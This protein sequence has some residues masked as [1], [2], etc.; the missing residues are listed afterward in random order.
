MESKKS[1]PP[2]KGMRPTQTPIRSYPKCAFLKPRASQ[3][4][5]PPRM[6]ILP[7]LRLATGE[8]S[9]VTSPFLI[10][11]ADHRGEGLESKLKALDFGE[12]E[13]L[14]TRDLR[15]TL[16]AIEKHMPVAILVDTLSRAGTE[17]LRAIDFA[18][19][20]DP[21]IPLL[22]FSEAR[23]VGQLSH[24]LNV[25]AHEA[26]DLTDRHA[27]GDEIFLRLSR[28]MT[29]TKR[30]EEIIDLRHRA[31][32]DDR[33][34]LLRVK[35]F[36]ARLV[37][38][39]S[40]CQRHNLEMAMVLIDLDK[41]GQINKQHNHTVGD[42]LIAQTGEVIRRTL[43]TEDVAGRIGG[44]EFAVVLPYTHKVDAARVVGRLVEEIHKLSGR[45]GKAT[46]DIA[47]SASIG[48]ETF[49]GRDLE[50]ADELRQH[51]ERALR[52]AK[53][54]GGNQGVYYRQIAQEEGESDSV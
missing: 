45:H 27:D 9:P 7:Q 5:I 17:E 23:Q 47:V 38:H 37:E 40:A 12:A 16:A 22:W 49:N 28:L 24:A 42:I 31:H 32:H 35:A 14:V 54:A 41:F 33:T 39:V 43:R 11:V 44:D 50:S 46:S 8:I 18:R 26:W 4:S 52:V 53:V 29:E 6:R 36:D 3:A 20:G 34:D 13:M 15:S 51:A 30:L 21:P 48:F 25:I 2:V 1:I 19:A 10:L